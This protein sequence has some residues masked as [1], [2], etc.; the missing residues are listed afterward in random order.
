MTGDTS[1]EKVSRLIVELCFCHWPT[2]RIYEILLMLHNTIRIKK[3]R[4]FEYL[5]L[6]GRHLK[7]TTLFYELF[8][9]NKVFVTICLFMTPLF[10][11][12]KERG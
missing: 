3:M 9:C 7:Y 10:D 5:A 4:S 8:V 6:K 2:I 11:V 1:L 12:Y